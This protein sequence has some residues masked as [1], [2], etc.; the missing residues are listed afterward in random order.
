[1]VFHFQFPK[2]TT[3]LLRRFFVVFSWQLCISFVQPAVF[4]VLN[5]QSST[6]ANIIW[7]VGFGGT[8][9]SL[10]AVILV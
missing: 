6:E 1:M 9:C 4:L 3:L 2:N 8:P 5:G 10:E 7:R